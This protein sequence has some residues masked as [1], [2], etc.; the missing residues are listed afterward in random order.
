MQETPLWMWIG[1]NAFVLLFL[2]LDLSVHGRKKHTIGIKESIAW[3]CFWIAIALF[4]NTLLYYTHGPQAALDFFT[5]Y[6]L[7]KSLSVDNLFVFILIFSY[8]KT[9]E[10]LLHKVLFYGILGAILMR[11][12]FIFGGIALLHQFSWIFYIFGLFLVYAGIKMI[13][14]KESEMHPES[15]FLI[16]WIKKWIPITDKYYGESFFV[17]IQDKLHG[18]PLFLTLLTVEFTDLVFAIDSIPAILAITLDPFIVYTSNIFAILGLR[19]LFFTLKASLEIF[20]FLS[21]AIGGILTFVGFKM[22]IAP[23][24][25]I[26]TPVT[27]CFILLS[28]VAAIILSLLFPKSEESNEKDGK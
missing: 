28:L 9:P 18:T 17:R 6:L 21:Y 10:H 13:N 12:L 8:F 22:L 19:A 25:K 26:P 11:A 16:E 23:W 3:S 24:L 20:H 7:E 27:L 14:Q 1:F 15:N 4:F 5:G 2:F